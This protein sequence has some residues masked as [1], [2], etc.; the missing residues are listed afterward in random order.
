MREVL[1]EC[2]ASPL[3]GFSMGSFGAIAEFSRDVEE[4][5]HEPGDGRLG[6]ITP[7]GGL[8]IRW[9]DDL[10]VLAWESLSRQRDHWQHGV[11]FCLPKAVANLPQHRG[12]TELGADEGALRSEQRGGGAVLFDLGLA[13]GFVNVCVRTADRSLQRVLREAAG[14]ELL[15]PHNPALPALIQAGP[16]RVFITSIGRLEVYQP[17]G[18]E[19]SPDG[20]HTH[21]L[22]KL[23]KRGRAHSANVPVP[24]GWLP[25]LALHPAHPCRTPRGEAK[26]FDRREHDWFQRRLE[27]AGPPGF[28]AQK[29]ATFAA[30]AG[31]EAP[32][33]F[34]PGRSRMA[35]TATRVALRQAR[36][37]QG[38]DEELFR[39]WSAAFDS[40]RHD[41]VDENEA[42]GAGRVGNVG[43][44][45]T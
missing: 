42:D 28:L 21:V 14:S 43:G 37:L 25:V 31:G 7:R 19:R 30:L 27:R 6:R 41:R 13:Q 36:Y 34:D 22:A 35:R 18:I 9:R 5:C 17:I 33:N 32:D 8:A 4:S 12:I 11:V 29:Q 38:F 45:A 39:C 26:A 3:H 24:A 2:L 15:A 23:L 1:T 40:V 16:H 10:M 20:P 44:A